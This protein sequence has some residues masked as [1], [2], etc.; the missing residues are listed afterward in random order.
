MNIFKQWTPD[1]GK[2]TVMVSECYLLSMACLR[3]AT[4]LLPSREKMRVRTRNYIGQQRIQDRVIKAAVLAPQSAGG[5]S[6][7]VPM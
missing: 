1:L 5:T 2:L 6:L 7:T 3:A 4:T